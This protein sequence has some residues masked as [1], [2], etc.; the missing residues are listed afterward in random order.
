MQRTRQIHYWAC[1]V[2]TYPRSELHNAEPLNFP[3]ND[4][5]S[6]LFI[7]RDTGLLGA[8]VGGS[9]QLAGITRFSCLRLVP[10][11]E[12][13]RLLASTHDG[14][15]QEKDYIAWYRGWTQV[16]LRRLLGGYYSHCMV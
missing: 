7:L 14:R 6:L 8:H 11:A 2:R 16:H 5:T 4:L 10:I 15:N 13:D 12:D 3:T 9:L 1:V